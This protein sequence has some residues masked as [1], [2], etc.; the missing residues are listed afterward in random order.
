LACR[1]AR[2]GWSAGFAWRI[3]GLIGGWASGRAFCL[4][5]RATAAGTTTTWL[6]VACP[7]SRATASCAAQLNGLGSG[8][9]IGFETGND[10]DGEFALDETFDVP[11]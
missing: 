4:I 9:W 5:L 1:T 3:A 2:F 6:T 11:Q 8:V 10:F 7:A